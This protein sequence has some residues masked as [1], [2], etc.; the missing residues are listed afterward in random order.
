MAFINEYIPESD[1]GKHD[2]RRVC[3][4]HNLR[5]RQDHMH[6]EQWTIDRERDIFL[7]KVWSHHESDFSGWAFCWKGH[8]MFFEETGMGGGGPK[9]D[10]TCWF[11]Y[12]IKGFSV[13]PEVAHER[14]AIVKDL[15]QAFADNCGGGVFSPYTRGT[16]T[17]EFI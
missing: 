4:A 14:D 5:W 1:Y 6:S 9:S 16:A 2:L 13:P 8:W 17:V 12:R 7:I 3:M 11:G 10:G 15:T